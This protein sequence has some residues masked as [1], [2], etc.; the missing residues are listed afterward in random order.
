MIVLTEETYFNE[1][2]K[3]IGNKNKFL[4]D[5]IGSFK[6]HYDIYGK[7]ISAGGRIIGDQIQ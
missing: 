3:I 5:P 2:I 6:E 4:I 7:V 1:L